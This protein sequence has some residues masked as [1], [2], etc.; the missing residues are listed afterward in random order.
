MVLGTPGNSRQRQTRNAGGCC[1]AKTRLK[2]L[3]QYTDVYNANLMLYHRLVSEEGLDPSLDPRK[4]VQK[5][6]KPALAAQG[7]KGTASKR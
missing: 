6:D 3:Y 4:I 7:T 5:I 1:G 2:E